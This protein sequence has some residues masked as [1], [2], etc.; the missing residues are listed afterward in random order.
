[1]DC[2]RCNESAVKWAVRQIA[3]SAITAAKLA[4]RV[5]LL[6]RQKGDAAIQIER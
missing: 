1:M 3:G 6:C 2:K 4:I 5:C